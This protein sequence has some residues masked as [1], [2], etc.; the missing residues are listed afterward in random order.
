MRPSPRPNKT[1][2]RMIGVD[3]AKATVVIYDSISKRTVAVEN[4]LEALTAA[5][6][7]YGPD[8]LLICEAT[9]GYELATLQAALDLGLPAHR[10]D[11]ARVKNFIRS[12]GGIAKTDK[13]D[14]QWLATYGQERHASLAL[15][16]AR[17][18]DRDALAALM[19]HRS[20][21]VAQRVQARNRK[22][23]PT[24]GRLAPYLDAEITF[25]D[26]Q[27]IAIEKD[28]AQI[29]AATETLSHDER[30]LRAIPSIGPVAARSLL[31][32][33]PELGTLGRRQAAS[34]AGLAPHPRQSGKTLNASRTSGGRSELRHI[35]FMVALTA[36]RSNA[37]LKA[38]YQRLV[39]A[40]KPKR[41]ALNAVA[42][43]I[44]VI[45]N[46]ALRPQISAPQLT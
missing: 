5:L 23:A 14:A 26:T 11:A 37:N 31:A 45:A 29:I 33:M 13:I 3:V 39:T 21:L 15:W 30:K 4:D 22:S 34:L 1:D 24:V 8:D 41:L 44:V 7:I 36:A 38:F 28:I 18:A 43:K 17:S 12:H 42:R 20:A 46:A 27:I 40:G 9:G 16:E 6:G 2:R 32:F 19:R 25:L 10:A 35:L